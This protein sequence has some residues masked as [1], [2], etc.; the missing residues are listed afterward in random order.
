MIVQRRCSSIGYSGNE[1]Y[2]PTIFR[3]PKFK[4]K[5]CCDVARARAHM[6]RAHG[7]S[8]RPR[9]A[10]RAPGDNLIWRT[11]DC[12]RFD[13][14]YRTAS[15]LGYCTLSMR[16]AP[17]GHFTPLSGESAPEEGSMAMGDAPCCP[18]SQSLA[19]PAPGL[20]KNGQRNGVRA[21][22]IQLKCN[23]STSPGAELRIDGT[24]YGPSD[25]ALLGFFSGGSLLIEDKGASAFERELARCSGQH[26]AASIRKPGIYTGRLCLP[27]RREFIRRGRRLDSRRMGSATEPGLLPMIA[28]LELL[29]SRPEEN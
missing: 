20:K 8:M 29:M 25:L 22:T 5:G 2:L 23:T 24:N 28:L 27:P 26:S 17:N 4:K 1:T 13:Y 21:A 19:R 11:R 3:I 7:S 10:L 16:G 12:A 18:S 15:R 14:H 9:R 6:L